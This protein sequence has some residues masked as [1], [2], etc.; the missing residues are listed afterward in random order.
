[1]ANLRDQRPLAFL[2]RRLLS[3][4]RRGG[5]AGSVRADYAPQLR[6]K[7]R[8]YRGTVRAGTR[9]LSVTGRLGGRW[10][11]L[12]RLHAIIRSQQGE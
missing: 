2:F 7:R 4:W 10:W 3:L 8:A 6:G 1:M 5:D 9:S 12:D 11:R